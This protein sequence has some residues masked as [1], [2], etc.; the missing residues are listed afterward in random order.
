LV[1][2]RGDFD[3]KLRAIVPSYA[4]DLDESVLIR[5]KS[6]PIARLNNETWNVA[7]AA[8]VGGGSGKS[9]VHLCI[10]DDYG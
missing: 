1:I 8:V 9:L 2:E 6:A 3:D 7:V 4:S 5:P 10:M